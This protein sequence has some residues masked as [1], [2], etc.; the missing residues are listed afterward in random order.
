MSQEN[1]EVVRGYFARQG[2]EDIRRRGLHPDVE[3]HIRSDFPDAGV[4][5]G[6]DGFRRLAARFDEV[7]AGQD[8]QPLEFIEAGARVVV[9]LRWTAE[10]R[11]SGAGFSEGFETWVFTVDGGLITTV[12]EF[13]TKQ[14]ALEAVGL[15]E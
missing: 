14:E 4:F 15:S 13:A 3:W 11:L 7:F 12:V 9:P 6:Q 8:Y 5:R 10:G 2:E 1:V